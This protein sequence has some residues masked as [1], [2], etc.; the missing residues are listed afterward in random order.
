MTPR[1]LN[2]AIKGGRI[3]YAP[4]TFNQI[5]KARSR[6]CDCKPGFA[7]C[8]HQGKAVCLVANMGWVPLS[9]CRESGS[10]AMIDLWAE[11]KTNELEKWG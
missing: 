6:A 7:G 9:Q 4:N 5:I 3:F 1:T 11:E 10:E 8:T 2:K